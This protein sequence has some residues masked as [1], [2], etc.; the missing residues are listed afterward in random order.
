M[1]PA[2]YKTKE[3]IVPAVHGNARLTDLHVAAEATKA[4]WNWLDA[5]M[6]A[7]TQE[8]LEKTDCLSWSAY[9]ASI[10]ETVI[11]PAAINALLPLFLDSAHSVAMIKHSMI[12]VQKAVQ[13]LNPGQVPILAA[14]QPLYALAKQIQWTWPDTLG[15]DHFIVMFGG[16]HIEM[17]LLKVCDLLITCIISTKM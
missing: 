1:L 7:L 5:V 16:L 4:E 12:I 3:F 14:D 11:P 6:E 17:A 10:Q 15:K 13:H 2:A 9:H 8:T